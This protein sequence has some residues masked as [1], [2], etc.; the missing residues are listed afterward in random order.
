MVDLQASGAVRATSSKVSGGSPA[1]LDLGMHEPHPWHT[2]G[3]PQL[4][5]RHSVGGPHVNTGLLTALTMSKRGTMA[6]VLTA[7][8]KDVWKVREQSCRHRKGKCQSERMTYTVG[9]WHCTALW[10]WAH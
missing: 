8:L 9:V 2:L 4:W 6:M 10:R 1:A 3:P 5:R 7:P